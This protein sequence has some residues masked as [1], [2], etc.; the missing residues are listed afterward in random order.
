MGERKL[1]ALPWYCRRCGR[2]HDASDRIKRCKNKLCAL[3]EEQDFTLSVSELPWEIA[4]TMFD[5]G[6]LK[7]HDISPE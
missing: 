4:L 6:F 2:S 3:Y 7:R 5:R 1:T